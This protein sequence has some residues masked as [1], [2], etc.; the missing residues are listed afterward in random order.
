MTDRR[1]FPTLSR[2]TLSAITQIRRARDIQNL[3]A[4]SIAARVT[5]QGYLLSRSAL[6]SI[7]TH[8]ITRLGLD[9]FVALCE[10]VSLDPSVV[11]AI[12]RD[13]CPQC[14]N[15][16]PRGFTCNTRGAVA[17]DD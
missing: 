5:E 13:D 12:A 2:V 8:R 3:S 14:S 16:P 9:A 1:N 7:E 4:E 6:A 15:Q 11:L 17:G 10:A